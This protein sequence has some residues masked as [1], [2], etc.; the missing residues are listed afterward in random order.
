[1]AFAVF[2]NHKKMIKKISFQ[3]TREPEYRNEAAIKEF[4]FHIVQFRFAIWNK[5]IYIIIVMHFSKIA[6][7]LLSTIKGYAEADLDKVFFDM[8]VEEK[9]HTFAVC[10]CI[11]VL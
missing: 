10:P 3:L 2:I 1:M 11:K 4:T 8:Y 9:L 6:L 7:F 5:D